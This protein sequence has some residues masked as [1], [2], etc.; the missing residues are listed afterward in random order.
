VLQFRGYRDQWRARACCP[1]LR[2]LLHDFGVPQPPAGAGRR[3]RLTDVLHLAELLQQAS[4]LLE[5]EHALVRH[6]AEQRQDSQPWQ[7]EPAAAAGKRCRPA[8]GGDVHKSKGLEY[9]LVFLPFAS[10]CRPAKDTDVPL[11]WQGLQRDHHRTSARTA[12]DALHAPAH[13][14]CQEG[15]A[16]PAHERTRTLVD[17]QLFR[18]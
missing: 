13:S 11:K 9:P 14:R 8:E 3:A 17:H 15:R 18:A 10:A 4:A 12:H 7:R 5:G 6:L 1:M 16:C 2:R